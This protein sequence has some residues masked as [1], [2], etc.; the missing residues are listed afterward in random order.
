MPDR[1][2]SELTQNLTRLVALWMDAKGFK[3]VETEVGVARKWIADVAGVCVPTQTE[4]VELKLLPPP[5]AWNWPHWPPS[6]EDE[7]KRNEAWSRFYTA[8]EKAPRI[9]T[10]LVEVKT[11][12][13][14]F[15]NDTKW[16]RPWPVNLCYLAIPDKMID[17]AQW[18]K[19]WGVLLFTRDGTRLRRAH[20]GDLHDIG[21]QDQLWTVLSL[22][23]RRDNVTRYARMRE[24]EKEVRLEEKDRVKHFTIS[25]A[26]HF[27]RDVMKGLPLEEAMKR[28]RVASLPPYLQ[29]EIEKLVRPEPW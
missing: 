18:P 27:L 24:W 23:Q 28:H 21:F 7:A 5:P 25:T 11:S 2:K 29:K 13:D 19:G 10:A 1:N 3:P 17:P 8:R 12:R 14:D 9:L 26:L 6:K 20:R 22:A 16:T 15:R 4:L